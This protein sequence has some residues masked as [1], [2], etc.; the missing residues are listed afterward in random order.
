VR[1]ARG[2]GRRP[3]R[4][5]L[6]AA[7]ALLALSLSVFA[8]VWLAAGFPT[9]DLRV[10]R[11]EGAAVAHGTSLYG[12]TV[13]RWH[14]PATYPPFAALGFV[15]LTWLPLPAAQAAVTALNVALL[16]LLVHLSLRL[17]GVAPCRR[18]PAVLAATA[19]GLWLEPVL[20]TMTFGQVNL[21]LACLVVWDLAR[22]DGARGKGLLIGIAAGIKLTPAIFAV[23]LAVTG[24]LRA[25]CAAAAAFLGTVLLGAAVLPGATVDFFT[26]RV[27]ETGRVGKGWIVDNQSLQGLFARLVHET[28]PGVFWP[29]A[30]VVTAVGGL[31]LAHR[32]HLHDD[33][34][35]WAL[36]CTAFTALLVCPISWT[37]H[38]VWCVPLLVQLVVRARRRGTGR[39]W[40][41]PAAVLAVF[42]ARTMWLV[43]HHGAG[44][45]HLTWWLQ[46]FGS[47]YPL[48]ALA[49]LAA[50]AWHTTTPPAPAGE[51]A[52][53]AGS[54]RLPGRRTPRDQTSSP[55]SS[56]PESTIR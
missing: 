47:P 8:A 48:L 3:C 38:W 12:F 7:A 27:F 46:P 2:T 55:A 1:G 10:Y 42:T 31:W 23:H 43:P 11:A 9:A 49:L 41:V 32:A 20:R 22:P 54:L 15:P 33:R 28:D 29:A 39:A 21:L 19:V 52:P 26:R 35:L 53:A 34:P 5:E 44:D 51:R 45:L 37:H 24:R 4:R 50:V 56:S 36:L 17:A 13:T 14:L 40:A 6:L 18:A 30:V 25:A 16:A